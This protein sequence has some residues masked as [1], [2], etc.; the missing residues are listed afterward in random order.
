MKAFLSHSSQDKEFVRAVANQL[1][2]QFCIFDEQAFSTGEEFKKSIEEGLDDAAVFVLFASRKALES[3]WVNF[4]VDEAWYRKIRASISK[5]LVYLIDSTV[6]VDDLP[7]WLRRALVRRENAPKVIAR[8]I[9]HHLD[10][11]LTER[12]HPYFVGRGDKLEELEQAITPVGK[13]APR[14]LF[15]TGL[16]GIGRRSLIRRTAPTT[17]TL[18]KQVEIRLGEGDSVKDICVT[19][20]DFIEPYSTKEGFDR[21]VE[22][23]K[24]LS[25]EE[26]VRR[27]LTDLRAL[28]A[29]GELPV[30]LD[31]GGL[32]DDDGFIRQPV[33]SILRSLSSNDTIYLFFVSHR[34]P[35]TNIEPEMPV[36]TLSPL[37]DNEIARLIVL[38]ANRIDLKVSEAE[39]AELS[40]YVAGYPP[41]A[42]F[43]VQQ[44]KNYGFELVNRE[45]SR[46]VQFR[47][48]VFLRHLSKLTLAQHEQDLLRVLATYSP[49]P[50]PVLA[51]V[52]KTEQEALANSLIQ[53]IDLAL[54]ASTEDGNFRIAD[55][56]SDAALKAFGYPSEEQNKAVAINLWDFLKAAEEIESSRLVLSRVLFRAAYIAREKDIAAQ[57]VR[58]SNDL[59]RLTETL[60]HERQYQKS[61]DTGLAAL[62]ER[63]ESTT[64][65]S[66]LVRSL[67]QEES[68]E[69]AQEQLRQLERYAPLRE[70]YFLRGFLERKRGRPTEAA[71]FYKKSQQAGRRGAAISRELALCYFLIGDIKQATTYINE[72]LERHGDDPYV[73]DLS[74][75]IALRRGDEQ[76]ARK[77]LSRLEIIDDPIYYLHRKSRV[78][79]TFGNIQGALKAARRAVRDS[80][81][82]Q[83]EVLAHLINCEIEDNNLPRAEKL[84]NKLDSL[85][86]NIRK[87]IR[88]ALRSRLEIARGR[89]G[90]ALLHT[91][92]IGN[93]NTIFYKRVRR[94]ALAGELRVSAL[95]DSVRAEYEEELQALQNQL[96]QS[97]APSTYVELDNF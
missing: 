56:I 9:R 65:R 35:Q 88:T 48:A 20:A 15:V 93:K 34:R 24:Q 7:E 42:Y 40:R 55:P 22:Q 81:H 47:T 69:R 78:E 32:L 64:A 49:L 16:P 45:K 23:I 94:D 19:I 29:A 97:A 38:L 21:I 13:P 62:E 37:K 73:V 82:P 72:A 12:Q 41:A 79:Y 70:V 60:Y 31:D 39:V 61:I 11:L 52:I 77:A 71:E 54:V 80:R 91:E 92:H 87:D 68:W 3:V 44:A 67:I 6:T 76:S 57:S 51:A 27:I 25:E 90:A 59:I 89:F 30:F 53:L 63:P 96:E 86:P 85:F 4:E 75:Q 18:K 2:R 58:L 5:S 50:L 17:L 36:I 26:A 28:V 95:K 14:A 46:L 8:D 43:T 1:G 84:L 66:Y 33:L 10:Q 83:F 74:I